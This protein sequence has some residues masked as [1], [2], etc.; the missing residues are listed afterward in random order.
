MA[1]TAEKALLAL[2]SNDLIGLGM[3]AD[4]LRR[5]LHPQNT[6][7]YTVLTTEMLNT[8]GDATSLTDTASQAAGDGC[9]AFVLPA[10]SLRGA[11][12]SSGTLEEVHA[13]Q[14]SFPELDLHGPGAEAILAC[15]R[16]SGLSL[17][18]VVRRLQD[19]GVRSIGPDRDSAASFPFEEV[20]AVHRASHQLG[21]PSIASVVMGTGE[22]AE[23][24]VGQID[25]VRRLQEET[26]GFV[27]FE[28]RVHH[29]QGPQARREEEA[30]AVDYLKTLAISRLM[31]ASIPHVQAGWTV[32]G[33]KVL[34]LA[35]RFG[36][37]D[38]GTVAPRWL[39]PQQPA[40]HSGEAELRRII[41][42]AGF[43]PV[44]RDLLYQRSL[45]HS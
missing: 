10:A 18:N 14:T 31:L 8:A 45:L 3:E 42:D 13:I 43:T 22:S 20:L 40:H 23:E 39:E 28:L 29:P 15:T 41:R 12:A 35:L 36:A 44:V 2:A 21:M 1:F 34:E 37:D 30:T 19:A 4:A 38:A 7:T 25:A 32:Q 11:L 33:P 26:F 17:G 27:A 5:T 9:V 6:V 16:D 24:R